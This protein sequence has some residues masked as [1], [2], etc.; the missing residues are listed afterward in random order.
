GRAAGLD[1]PLGFLDPLGRLRACPGRC[2]HTQDYQREQS[3]S[4][5]HDAQSPFQVLQD[6]NNDLETISIH[7]LR[8]CPTSQITD[9]STQHTIVIA[10]AYVLVNCLI[11]KEAVG[12][13]AEEV[14]PRSSPEAPGCRGF[15][16]ISEVTANAA[17]ASLPTLAWQARELRRG[18]AVA[19]RAEADR[20]E[21]QS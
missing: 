13:D 11:R 14:G 20:S 16:E 5:P 2:R 4:G 8:A 9:D 18:L 21:R 3:H 17:P 19:R 1:E 12:G 6:F 7:D 15:S 10:R